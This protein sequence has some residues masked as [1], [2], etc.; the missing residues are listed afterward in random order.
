MR[1]V[2]RF[3]IN[4]GIFFFYTDGS[5][6]YEPEPQRHAPT[7]RVLTGNSTSTQSAVIV[8]APFNPKPVLHFRHLHLADLL[9]GRPHIEQRQWRCC[10]RS[11][12]HRHDH[13]NHR[14]TDRIGKRGR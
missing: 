10:S 13:R 6:V 8:P 2:H 9:G 11:K 4:R 3:P 7:V 1:A 14:E 5:T 12:K